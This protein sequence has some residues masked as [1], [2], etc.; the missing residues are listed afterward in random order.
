LDAGLADGALEVRLEVP[1]KGELALMQERLDNEARV[2]AELAEENARCRTLMSNDTC[3][4]PP[5]RP[6][7]P[8]QPLQTSV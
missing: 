3:A 8:N 2:N 4:P 7:E 6:P 5:C 1:G